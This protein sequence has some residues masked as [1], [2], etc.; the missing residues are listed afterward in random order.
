VEVVPMAIP[1]TRHR[2]TVA[3]YHRMAEVGIL[4]EDDRVEL[5]RGEIVDMTPIGRKHQACVDRLTRLVV[6]GL[7]EKV[8]VRVQ[9]PIR[10]DEHSE[11]QPDLALLRDCPD[12]YATTD[13]APEDVLLVVEV[14]DT[15]AQHDREV[16]VPLYAQAG[17]PEVWLVN[18]MEDA[19]TVYREPESQ[20]YR[21]SFT[22]KGHDRLSPRSFPDFVLTAD[23]I[24]G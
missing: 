19:I 7:G 6:R 10:L 1:V 17:I 5:I 18:L 16:K 13:A 20:R 15:S 3:E 11:P 8:I 4:A 2:F 14:A 9:G 21:T 23:Q 24:L 22:I 12:F